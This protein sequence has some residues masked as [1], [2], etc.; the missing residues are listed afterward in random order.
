MMEISLPELEDQPLAMMPEPA[1]HADESEA[2]HTEAEHTGTGLAG[3]LRL[4]GPV[5]VAA[6]ETYVAGDGDLRTFVEQ[7][8]AR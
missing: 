4:G 6:S 8:A 3:R 7:E 2:E 1:A 5:A